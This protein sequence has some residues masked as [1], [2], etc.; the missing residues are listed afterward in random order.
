[1]TSTH[2]RPRRAFAVRPVCMF[3]QRQVGHRMSRKDAGV[4]MTSGAWDATAGTLAGRAI[5]FIEN[6][7]ILPESRETMELHP[8]QTD[9]VEQ[10]ADT[11][12]KCHAT[13]IGAGNAKTTTL[14]AFV[15]ACL[16]LGNEAS[17]PVVADT[18]PQ[19]WFTTLGRVKRF[20]ELHPQLAARSRILE[21]QGSR[22]GIYVPYHGGRAFAVASKPSGLQGLI[23][24]PIAVLEEMSEQSI[25]TFGALMNRLGKRPGKVV[26]ISTPSFHEDNA[27]LAL[28]RRAQSGE[29]LPG[30]VMTQYISDQK[31]HRDEA[32]W[33]MANPG[34][35]WNMPDINA[36]RTD[37]ATLPEQMFRCYRLCQ[38]PT[39][40]ESCWLNSLDDDGDGYELWQSLT[41][42]YRLDVDA[43]T[44]V[45]VDVAKS[46]DHAAVVWG[47]FRPDGRL[48]ARCKIWTP[49]SSA[50]IDLDE[51]GVFL[52]ELCAVFDVQM[53]CYDP[54]YFYNAPQ[55]AKQGL[56]MVEGIQT[57]AR[58]APLVG[59]CYASIRR[60][61][62]T[63]DDDE[64]FTRHVLAGKRKI[65]SSGYTIEK[66]EYRN[67][68]DA[69][70]ALV[71][72]HGVAMGLDE[73]PTETTLDMLGV[74]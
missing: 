57:D 20:V 55:L 54:A 19:A 23:P 3:M 61:L 40:G 49:T 31:D 42:D 10:W 22:Q 59:H 8:Y 28:Q 12:T 37:L 17:I 34:L 53:I 51:I 33:T 43:A 48:H 52:T 1:T 13:V 65:C 71:L 27:L 44:W 45:G 36:I 56:P 50:T 70:V 5:D 72:M 35:E 26:G 30:V 2:S 63:H 11:A 39:G 46:Y 66:R 24:G 69:A 64:A 47:Q 74:H 16:F 25:A 62:V 18:V 6:Y 7:C 29:Q 21:G 68:C 32:G 9:L 67:K 58:M 60:R 15:T 73:S 41:S 4:T 14:G 38:L